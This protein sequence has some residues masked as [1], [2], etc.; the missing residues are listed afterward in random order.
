MTMGAGATQR[1]DNAIRQGLADEASRTVT[2]DQGYLNGLYAQVARH[3]AA[4]TDSKNALARIKSELARATA[5][6]ARL[7]AENQV[8]K[9]EKTRFMSVVDS[10]RRHISI[11]GDTKKKWAV[12]LVKSQLEKARL[13]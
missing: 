7:R 9:D 8:L 12:S 10:T 4:A 1:G 3:E 6:V 2:V 11:A 13:I 5:L